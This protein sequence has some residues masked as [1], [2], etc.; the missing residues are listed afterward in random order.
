[1]KIIPFEKIRIW[2]IA[3]II[4]ILSGLGSLFFFKNGE[5]KTYEVVSQDFT[6]IIE[7]TG[8]VVPAKEINLSFEVEGRVNGVYVDDGD[9]VKAGQVLAELSFS[10]IEKQIAEAQAS[11]EVEKLKLD[12]I[13]GQ[14]AQTSNKTDLVSESLLNAIKNA[15]VTSDNIVKNSIDLF[16]ENADSRF[17]DFFSV[18]KD[19]FIRQDI[20]QQRYE[21]GKKLEDWKQQINLLDK[22]N[23]NLSDADLAIEHLKKI[24]TLLALISENGFRLEPISDVSQS[25]IDAYIQGISQSRSSI[26]N[27]ITLVE[28]AKESYRSVIAEAPIQQAVLKNS[29][30]NL[31][32]LKVVSDK[33][34]IR[35][36]F[37]G[38]ITQKNAENGQFIK[39][40]E[41][42]FSLISDQTLE[43]ETFIPEINI[44]GVA[45]GDSVVAELD[46]LPNQ[47]FKSQISHID[48]QSTIKDGVT[49]YKVDIVFLEI[50]QEIRSGMTVNLKITKEIISDQIV[51]PAYLVFEKDKQ[52]FVTVVME[53]NKL[54]DKKIIISKDDGK[55]NYL[56]DSGIKIGDKILVK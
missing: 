32:R 19:Y 33:Y 23:I 41:T 3:V 27:T 8:T 54:E 46:A 42:I 16:I 5:L 9:E 22:K 38:V 6:R 28:S 44:A 36:P 18:L 39:S 45:V 48:P 51:I 10:E 30:A 24:E 56:I 15:Y 53:N 21:I 17:P 26:L 43:V 34:V 31:E 1:M 29:Q 12:E 25:R 13:Q 49:T 2:A 47:E 20:Q 37:D 35:A 7:S 52:K 40:G 4:L 14:D 55:G 11:L 50:D